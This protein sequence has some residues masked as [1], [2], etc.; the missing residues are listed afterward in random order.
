[1]PDLTP[2]LGLKKPKGNE[3]VNRQS[4][5]ENYDIIDEKVATKSEFQ[6]HTSASN[7]H[8]ITPSL[9]GAVK[10]A[11]GV[12][13]AQ[14]GTLSAR[15]SAGVV[16]RIYIASD[17]KAIYYDNGSTWVQVATLS[18]NDLT[19]KPSSFTPSAHASSHRTGGGDAIAPTDIG[20]ASSTDLTNHGNSKQTHGVSG[21]YYI[22]KTS[23]SD[24][25]PAW[26]DV[27]GKPSSYTPSAHASSHRTGGGDAIAPTDIGAAS[28]TDLT[29]HG[30]SKQTHGVSGSYYIAKTSRSDQ[31]PAWSDVQG[32]PSSYTPSAHASTHKTGGTD[33]LTPAD[34]GAAVNVVYTATIQAANW[35]GSEAPFSQ[36]VSVSGILSTDTPIIDVV[37]SGTYGTDIERSS[38]WNYVYRA[39]TGDNSITF[40]AKTKPTID[41]PIQIKVVR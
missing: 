24:Q 6:A 4:F 20:A 40:Y 26:G 13:Q 5:N 32:K 7:P 35:S 18:W 17:T 39:V 22:A 1:M 28:S 19:N 33:V 25:L 14:V 23:R 21:S 15:P 38:Q 3:I 16:G 11:G 27:Q 37:M 31:L 10:N 12:V 34:I 41:L 8:N 36:S 9:I 30:N 29:N 2:R